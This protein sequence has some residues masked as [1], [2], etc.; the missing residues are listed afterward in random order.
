MNGDM[1]L[2]GYGRWGKNIARELAALGRLAAIVDVNRDVRREIRKEYPQVGVFQSLSELSGDIVAVLIATP[3]SSHFALS[4]AALRLGFHVFVEKPICRDTGSAEFLVGL[5]ETMQR[6]LMVGHLLLYLPVIGWIGRQI[7]EGRLGEVHS[8][9][10]VRRGPA[11]NRH[12]EAVHWTFGVHDLAI[13]SFLFGELSFQ[14]V[15]TGEE[16]TQ[17]YLKIAEKTNLS[18]HF[19]RTWPAWERGFSVIGS[20]GVLNYNEIAGQ[21]RTWGE[22]ERWHPQVEQTPLRLELVAFCDAIDAGK[23]PLSTGR[24]AIPIIQLLEH[25]DRVMGRQQKAST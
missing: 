14:S 9:H 13:A 5:A 19:S 7:A 4:D 2:V 15:L 11:V 24:S 21:I 22:V 18:F 17:I 6:Q 16:E 1:A 3:T 10:F 25:C 23:E 8:A 12:Q 20:K